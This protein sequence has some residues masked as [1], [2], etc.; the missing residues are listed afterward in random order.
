MFIFWRGFTLFVI[1]EALCNVVLRSDIYINRVTTT[2]HF[3]RDE[4]DVFSSK[5]CLIGL[6]NELIY[7]IVKITLWCFWH[8]GVMFLLFGTSTS[9]KYLLYTQ[10]C[11]IYPPCLSIHHHKCIIL[12][13]SDFNLSLL[14]LS[15]SNV[16]GGFTAVQ[17]TVRG[18]GCIHP[19]GLSLLDDFISPISRLPPGDRAHWWVGLGSTAQCQR[20]IFLHIKTRIGLNCH[21]FGT[22]CSNHK[23]RKQRTVRFNHCP[24]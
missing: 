24:I 15:T 7:T 23:Y 22:V 2:G 11:R 12:L 14:W 10:E 9:D 4:I 16:I 13:T 3:S 6:M 21:I 5:K 1:W 8:C 19:E 18:T 17:S 20:H